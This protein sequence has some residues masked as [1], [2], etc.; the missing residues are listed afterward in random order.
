[1]IIG[2]IIVRTA[3]SNTKVSGDIAI[4]VP[5]IAMLPAILEIISEDTP[6]LKGK[7]LA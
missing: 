5:A 6:K 1:M 3:P 2:V 4:T 7:L